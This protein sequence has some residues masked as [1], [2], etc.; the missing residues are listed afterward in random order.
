M[1]HLFCIR[2]VFANLEKIKEIQLFPLWKHRNQ[3][4]RYDKNSNTWYKIDFLG[5]ESLAEVLVT[6]ILENS[7]VMNFCKYELTH[8]TVDKES[9][10]GCKSKSFMENSENLITLETLANKLRNASLGQYLGGHAMIED[11]IEA[12][13]NVLS[14]AK[15]ENYGKYFTQL[16]ELDSFTLNDDRH[17]N[18]VSCEIFRRKIWEA[19]IN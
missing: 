3:F 8:L 19:I 7:N 5:Y 15:I 1:A 12:V 2:I 13:L 11:K 4:T 10:V 18:N 16:I 9:Y 6:D 14:D 17:T